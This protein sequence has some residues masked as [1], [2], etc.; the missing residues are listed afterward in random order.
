MLITLDELISKINE[1]QRIKIT[2]TTTPSATSAATALKQLENKGKKIRFFP[3]RSS[4]YNS[5]VRFFDADKYD[6]LLF[7]LH[8]FPEWQVEDKNMVKVDDSFSYGIF[9]HNGNHYVTAK[10]NFNPSKTWSYPHLAYRILNELDV[11]TSFELDLLLAIGD[12]YDNK[13]LGMT[14]FQKEIREKYEKKLPLA[15]VFINDMGKF[16]IFN[17]P[18]FLIFYD[19]LDHIDFKYD[20]I[21]S[22]YGF[23]LKNRVDINKMLSEF[24][25]QNSDLARHILN[26][27]DD[28]KVPQRIWNSVKI[29]FDT[30]DLINFPMYK[31][32][33]IDELLLYVQS[34]L[35]NNTPKRYG[36]MLK[37]TFWSHENIQDELKIAVSHLKYGLLKDIN[38]YKTHNIF[39]TDIQGITLYY[40]FSDAL[41]G[42]GWNLLPFFKW[43][44]VFLEGVLGKERSSFEIYSKSNIHAG[45]IASLAAKMDIKD[46]SPGHGT[47]NGEFFKA[48]FFVKG[49]TDQRLIELILGDILHPNKEVLA[50][51]NFARYY[52][53]IEG[54]P[55]VL[56]VKNKIDDRYQLD[57]YPPYNKSR[58]DVSSDEFLNFVESMESLRK[59]VLILPEKYL[60]KSV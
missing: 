36:E 15:P 16:K 4:G 3:L 31:P 6:L 51:D 5:N 45:A 12:R 37:S 30:E 10:K 24:D 56:L 55:I 33:T 32:F 1:A 25:L 34:Y 54:K 46:L 57:I 44:S 59:S 27:F 53:V 22:D 19:Y 38:R 29:N 17:Y 23:L 43:G 8:K 49:Y 21:P 40:T 60:L 39:A 20:R 26:L 2:Y 11:E 52:S 28:Q 35:I 7:F 58:R 42:S 18:T 50:L 41:Y 14:E 47:G 13:E 9:S 48:N